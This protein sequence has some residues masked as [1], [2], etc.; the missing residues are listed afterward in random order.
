MVTPIS[1]SGVLDIAAVTFGRLLRERH[2]EISPAEVL[3]VRAVL[4]VVGTT[5]RG[6]LRSALRAVTVKY[7]R[8][9]PGFDRTFDHFFAGV[10]ATRTDDDG[11]GPGAAGQVGRLPDELELSADDPS[12]FAPS[13]LDPAEIG[14][15]VEGEETARRDE[16]MHYDDSDFSTATGQEEFAVQEG[17]DRWESSVTYEIEV[18]RASSDRAG[19]MGSSAISVSGDGALEWSDALDILRTLDGYDAR[20]VYSE[21]SADAGELTTE[22]MGMFVDAVV[23]FLESVSDASGDGR[24]DDP[25]ASRA[26]D[27]AG[28]GDLERASH[29]VMRRIRGAPRRRARAFAHGGLDSRATLRRAWATDGEAF[30]IMNRSRVPGPLKLVILV[31]V[32][33]SV[34]PVTGFVLRLAQS[35]HRKVNRCSVV[36]FVDRPVDVTDRLLSSSGDDALTTVLAAP[37]L[38]LEASSDYGRMFTEL[39]DR[40]GHL[41]DKRTSVLVVGDGRSNGLDPR[42]DQMAVISRRSHRVAWITPEARRYWNQAT[43]GLGSYE[44]HLDGIVTARDPAELSERAGLLGSALG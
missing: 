35:L 21:H 38:D 13:D 10:D 18:D 32:S 31:D 12:S 2:V 14:D 16:S 37:G 4:D 28:L 33:L 5:D 3:E 11:E 9:N 36:A 25:E 17:A 26:Q 40:H 44:Q 29:E 1:P 7:Q 42:T 19:E 8:E 41:V 20:R 15:L 23:A 27:R 34:R 39:L 22:Q 30:T 43:C 24:P 6:V